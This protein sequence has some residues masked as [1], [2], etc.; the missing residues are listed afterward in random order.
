MSERLPVV[1][2]AGGGTG[3]HVFPMVAVADALRAEADVRVVYVGTAR[4]I[5]ARVVPARGDELQLLDVLPIKGQG[6]LG[7]VK[8]AVRA[9]TLVPRARSLLRAFAPGAVL[10]VGG[11][12]AGPVGLGAWLSRIPVAILEPNST[13]GLA[14][15]WLAPFAQRAY[16]AH[17][18]TEKKLGPRIA[19]RTGV[20]LRG[21]F[22]P[23]PYTAGATFRILVLGG[24]QGAKGLNDVLP[25]ALVAARRKVDHLIVVHQ[26]GRERDE[27]V[28]ASYRALGAG[29]WV[30]VMPFLDD[31]AGEL[32]AADLVIGRA[33]ASSLGELCAVGRASILIPFP[34]AAD[35]HQRKNAEAVAAEG[36]AIA[37]L[38]ADAS[39]ARV[40]AEV[41]A[42][43]NDSA[44]RTA[45]ADRAR[46][47]GRPDAARTIAR[48]LLALAGIP[49]RSSS[50]GPRGKDG[51][52]NRQGA[53]D[54]RN[55]GFFPG[56]PGALAVPIS[57]PRG[58]T[59]RRSEEGAHV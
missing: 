45:M 35:D 17:A 48:D 37:I 53:R 40:A 8:G 36:A 41:V 58:L 14:N 19:R 28:R 43:A 7:A 27:A 33:G 59:D 30:T 56:G 18:E 54:A 52:E 12:A 44:R 34:F 50:S 11:Y 15:R 29:D 24:S 5:E 9:A 42:L 38:Q 16:V 21:V 47:L 3:G 39:A 46:A 49:A 2:L 51:G 32:A 57:S 26:A 4:G 22:V 55:F 23:A 20:P 31:V 13:L 10:A 6:P 25:E 1:V